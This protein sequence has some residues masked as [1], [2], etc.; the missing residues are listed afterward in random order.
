MKVLIID[1]VHPLVAER[2]SKQGWQC[3]FM[4]KESREEIISVIQNYDGLVLRS[5]IKIDEDFLNKAKN[6]KF[7]GRPGAGLENIDLEYCE[8]NDIQ[9][10]RSPEG[11]RDAVAEHAVGMI[12][13]LLNNLKRADHEV[14]QGVWKREENRGYELMG[15]TIGI[16]GYG[17]MGKAFAQRLKGFGVN[18]IA[19]DKYEHNFTD[20]FAREITL[21]EL[22]KE[23]DIIS[24]HLPQSEETIHYIDRSFIETCAK[25]FYLINTARG[26]SVNTTDLLDALD[27]GK[28]LGACLDVLELESSSFEKMEGSNEVFQRLVAS[29]KVVLSPHIAGWTHEAKY[30]LADFLVKKIF[31][32]F[33]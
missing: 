25:P 23:A 20:E 6:L 30:K 19:H 22:K 11:N 32:V 18:V 21:E 31:K 28:I 10:F 27:T 4:L 24:L 3:D 1:N 15:K 33:A 9:V 26:K 5:R 12:L 14:R 17:F 2:F 29:D 7:I 8:R 16:I 13:M